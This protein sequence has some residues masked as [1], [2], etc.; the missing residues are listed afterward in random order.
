MW[1]IQKNR[2]VTTGLLTAIG[3]TGCAY[4]QRSQIDAMEHALERAAQQPEEAEAVIALLE[5]GRD[6]P[7]EKNELIRAVL[8]RNPSLE[9]ARLTWQAVVAQ[10]P[11]ATALSDPN[12]SYSLAPASI[13]SSDVRYGQVVKI[14]QR[15]PWPST[16]GLAGDVVLSD[17]VRVPVDDQHFLNVRQRQCAGADIVDSQGIIGQ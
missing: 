15:F 17:A 3:L 1:R 12:V 6:G 9:S 4:G 16:L 5:N 8:A 2:A 10:Q 11:Q 14:E 13:R 7:L